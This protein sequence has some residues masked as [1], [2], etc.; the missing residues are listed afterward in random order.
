MSYEMTDGDMPPVAPESTQRP[1]VQDRAIVTVTTSGT[2]SGKVY[3]LQKCEES[4]KG[5]RMVRV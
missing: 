5:G 4:S 1:Q 2:F 3:L